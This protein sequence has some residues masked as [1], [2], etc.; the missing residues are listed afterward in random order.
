MGYIF[1]YV[2][3][4]SVSAEIQMKKLVR[5]LVIP[6]LIAVAQAASAANLAGPQPPQPVPPIL[7][8]GP[9]PTTGPVDPTPVEP[10]PSN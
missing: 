3:M 9:G 5:I 2:E 1:L 10:P 7:Y 6:A 8:P 4:F